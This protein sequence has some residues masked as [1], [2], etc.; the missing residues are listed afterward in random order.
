MEE[1]KRKEAEQKKKEEED[2]KAKAVSW[3]RGGRR[4]AGVLRPGAD[5]GRGI[6]G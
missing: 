6:W 3:G 5:E 1:A 2:A 4:R